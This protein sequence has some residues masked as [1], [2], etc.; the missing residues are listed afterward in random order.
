MAYAVKQRTAELGVRFALGAPRPRVLWMVFRESLMLVVAGL[1]IGLPLVIGAGPPDRADAVRRQPERSGRSSASRPAVLLVVGASSSYLPALARVARRSA[2]SAAT[3]V[4]GIKVPRF[5]RFQGCPGVPKVSVPTWY[6]CSWNRVRTKPLEPWNPGTVGTIVAREQSRAATR[7]ASPATSW[8][9]RNSPHL[10]VGALGKN[11]VEVLRK[12]KA[13]RGC[14]P[15]R[16]PRTL[17]SLSMRTFCQ[18]ELVVNI[19]A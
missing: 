15:G 2:Y 11:G 13:G 4:T 18:A 16:S 17:P 3:G 19:F 8:S 6:P 14:A 7:A 9:D 5:Q 1:V 12:D 10:D